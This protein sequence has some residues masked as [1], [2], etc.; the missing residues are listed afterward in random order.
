MKAETFTKATVAGALGVG[1]AALLVSGI[2]WLYNK[3]TA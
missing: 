1:A 3:F 2:R